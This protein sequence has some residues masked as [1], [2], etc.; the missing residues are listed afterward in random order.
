MKIDWLDLLAVQGALKSLLQDHSS[1]ASILQCSAFV[2]VQLSQSS[3]T[4]GKTIALTVESLSAKWRLRF[5]THC[6]GPSQLSY[7]EAIAFC[8]HGCGG[9]RAQGEGVCHCFPSSPSICHEEMGPDAMITFF[10]MFSFKL[11]FSLSSFK[12]FFSSSLLSAI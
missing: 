12:R 3:V 8:F 6:L 11:A 2:M 5:L 1:K 10:L 4:T 9:L 7:Q